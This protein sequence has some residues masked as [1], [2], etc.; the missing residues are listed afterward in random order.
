MINVFNQFFEHVKEQKIFSISEFI[1][2][3]EPK[4]EAAGYRQAP[5][6][7]AYSVRRQTKI[8]IIHDAV[9]GDFVIH[10]GLI[11]EIRR[12][13]PGAYI[14]LVVKQSAFQLAELCPYV[15]EVIMNRGKLSYAR[16]GELFIDYIKLA[17]KLLPYKFDICFSLA[18]M[19]ETQML[20]YMSGA[21]VRISC[22]VYAGEFDEKSF[23]NTTLFNFK[24]AA[25]FSTHIVPRIN[26]R[27]HRVDMAFSM[28]EYFLH[29]PIENRSLEIW[30]SPFD[31]NVAKDFV[32]G[33][34]PLYALCMGGSHPRKFYP[35][36]KYAKFLELVVSDE[37]SAKFVI[38]GGG[39][40]DLTSA[41]ILK[42]SV[43]KIYEENVI[44][45][46]NKISYRQSAAVLSL[47]NAYIGNDTGTMHVAAAVN[48]PVMLIHYF[49]SDVPI[50]ESDV[51]AVYYPYGV[52]NVIVRPKNAL[53][54][55][56]ADKPHNSYGCRILIQP[57]CITQIN[58]Q[59]LYDGFK[60][61]KK[62]I[63]ENNLKPLYIS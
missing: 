31:L 26:Y 57:H 1:K 9:V 30:Y 16:F 12:V 49:P 20:M 48:C 39:N 54:E 6:V 62:R 8:L 22:N 50:L 53:P 21:R 51:I 47:C 3:M 34:S 63:S 28:L 41:E 29:A 60:F 25:K 36:E 59:I 18:Y 46:T 38:L 2:E 17:E 27:C 56:T 35:P 7:T 40:N 4:F 23:S 19:A 45:L 14:V 11:R 24:S 15:D 52:P 43:P 10:T 55:C 61:L 13:Y 58:P 33:A 32:A 37:P 42:N 5:K 44:D